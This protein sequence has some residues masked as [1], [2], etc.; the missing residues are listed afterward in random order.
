MRSISTTCCRV[1]LDKRALV[2]A[3]SA[4]RASSNAASAVCSS[5]LLSRATL[6]ECSAISWRRCLSKSSHSAWVAMSSAWVLSRFSA[7]SC[8]KRRSSSD[9]RAAAS[10]M[11]ISWACCAAMD[12][13]SSSICRRFARPSRFVSRTRRSSCCRASLLSLKRFCANLKVSNWTSRRFRI[14]ARACLLRLLH[15][16]SALSSSACAA[17]T[18]VRLKFVTASLACSAARGS[19]GSSASVAIAARRQPPARPWAQ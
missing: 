19:M 12:A 14:F 5:C 17:W 10:M 18:T 4:R 9:A 16:M 7:K 11:R 6:R 3:S 13:A 8:N 15:S 2:F 1:F